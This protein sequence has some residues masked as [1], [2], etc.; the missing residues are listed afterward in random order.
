[1]AKTDEVLKMYQAQCD[2]LIPKAIEL[3]RGYFKKVN[4]LMTDESINICI[5]YMGFFLFNALRDKSDV[6]SKDTPAETASVQDSHKKGD[7]NAN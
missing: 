1:M 6:S 7:V 2:S 5:S 4:P 3:L